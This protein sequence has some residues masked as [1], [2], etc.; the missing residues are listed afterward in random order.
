MDIVTPFNTCCSSLPIK[1]IQV[2][3]RIVIILG[4]DEVAEADRG[5][6]HETVIQR[7][8]VR[9][10]FLRVEKRR[11]T[12][13]DD[14]CGDEQN[15]HDPVDR[16]FPVGKVVVFFAAVPGPAPGVA[17]RH[18]R[19]L[20]VPLGAFPPPPTT[21]VDGAQHHRQHGDDSL[22]EE[23]KEENASGT[24]EKTVDD[25]YHLASH[26]T[27]RRHAVTCSQNTRKTSFRI[28]TSHDTTLFIF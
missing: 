23:I 11:G 17:A 21:L 2:D 16:R 9:P 26:S 12:A 20:A 22:E 1:S 15:Q 27:G 14:R 7:V 28:F 10:F 6:R 8:E 4:G 25:N 13:G 24:A 19:S 5:E 18:D 3:V